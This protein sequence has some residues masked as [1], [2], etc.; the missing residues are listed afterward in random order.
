MAQQSLWKKLVG[1]IERE[2]E[3][4][5]RRSSGVLDYGTGPRHSGHSA[6]EQA[7]QPAPPAP[8]EE[9]AEII[10]VPRG[11][12]LARPSP[13]APAIDQPPTDSHS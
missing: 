11:T 1:A 7:D 12:R 6:A 10:N 9:Q 8:D 2:Y 3:R 4:R 13:P 5:V